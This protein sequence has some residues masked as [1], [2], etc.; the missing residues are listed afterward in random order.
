MFRCLLL[1]AAPM[2]IGASAWA[3]DNVVRFDFE[4]GDLQGGMV[5]EGKSDRL[6]SD[7]DVFHNAY[8][9]RP[10]GK[11]NQQGQ[12]LPLDGRAAAGRSL[13]ASSIPRPSGRRLT[14]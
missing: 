6:L 7:R 1:L 10:D 12:V 11:Y 9:Q 3:A 14:I 5:V 8:P 4:S 2:L 13:P